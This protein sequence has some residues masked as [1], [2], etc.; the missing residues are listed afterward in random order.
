MV[1]LE[2][3]RF[4][5]TLASAI[6][7]AAAL[8]PRFAQAQQ[9]NLTSATV[10]QPASAFAL[11]VSGV[12]GDFD[13]DH[14]ADLAVAR[15]QGLVNGAYRYRI[16][17]FFAGQPDSG[18]D[19]ESGPPGGLHISAR[20]VDGDQDLDLVLTSEFGR[21][22]VGIWINNGHGEFTKALAAGYAKSVWQDTDRDFQAPGSVNPAIAAFA[23]SAGGW[24][25]ETVRS[26]SPLPDDEK[27]TCPLAAAGPVLVARNAGNPLRAPP[28]L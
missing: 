9:G 16:Q 11:R 1:H 12:L 17:V 24:S 19:L 3:T 25:V 22:P 13:G 26:R 20:D 23:V 28:S 14:R 21:E 6:A 7:L 5:A 15:P 8:L 4:R 2:S 27:L 18:F 10:L